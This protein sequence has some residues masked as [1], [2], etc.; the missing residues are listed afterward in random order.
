MYAI[1][2]YY[3][4]EEVHRTDR[5]AGSTDLADID[6][7][8][9]PGRRHFQCADVHDLVAGYSA[10]TAA[11]TV[12]VCVPVLSLEQL[13]AGINRRA[14]ALVEIRGLAHLDGGELRW[15]GDQAG[16]AAG[17]FVLVD[18]SFRFLFPDDRVLQ[19][20]TVAAAAG[21]YNFV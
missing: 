3:D 13:R 15:A 4:G 18:L 1:R 11:D 8:L 12:V 10:E 9:D 14:H 17:A 16:A 21:S 19:A 20:G 6:A 2:S 7:R 5:D